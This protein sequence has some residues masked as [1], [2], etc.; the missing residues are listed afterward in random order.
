MFGIPDLIKCPNCKSKVSSNAKA[1]PTC[2]YN[3]ERLF[4]NPKFLTI[5][6]I[7]LCATLLIPSFYVI[8]F[9]FHLIKISFEVFGIEVLSNDYKTFIIFMGFLVSLISSG[10]IVIKIYIKILMKMGK[11]EKYE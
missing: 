5:P 6:I 8:G 4:H 1:C 7:L 3:M 2:G 9:I 10:L 11:L